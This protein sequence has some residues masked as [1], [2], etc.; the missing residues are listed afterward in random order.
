MEL[1]DDENYL[2]ADG[3]RH[4]R[5][6]LLVGDFESAKSLDCT[7]RLTTGALTV[8][9]YSAYQTLLLKRVIELRLVHGY[10]FSRIAKALDE[11]GVL[12]SKGVRL[13]AEHVYSIF[14][15]GMRRKKRLRAKPR[16]RLVAIA[17][18]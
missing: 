16:I 13:A 1:N 6:S 3:V 12:S 11:E 9:R 15:K 4:S 14:A 7:F 5:I 17:T 8:S 10:S 18:R 2:L